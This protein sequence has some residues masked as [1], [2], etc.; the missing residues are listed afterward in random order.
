MKRNLKVLIADDSKDFGQNCA[1]TLTNYGMEVKLCEKD[2]LAI[3]E[4]IKNEDVDVVIADVFMP[5]LDV[6][7]VLSY[8]NNSDK[9]EKPLLMAMS[10]CDNEMLEKKTLEAG[11][12]YFFIKPFDVRTMAQRII[13]L[14]DLDID[15][16]PVS[17]G[18]TLSKSNT[19]S[20]AKLEIIVTEIIHD[21][22]IPAHI[23]GYHY[24]RD[25]IIVS[26]R[27]G[28]E[29]N[30]VTKILYPTIA[31]HFNT[32]SSRVE[33]AIRHAIEV[34]WDRGD[35]DVL[36]SYFGYTVQNQRGKPTNAEFIA[37]ISDK[38]RIQLRIG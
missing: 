5:H 32:T 1:K 25:A 9:E 26:V 19:I 27:Q 16:K 4:E 21:I 18:N 38:I 24:L 30:S 17:I 8:I 28:N 2:G 34:A 22:G 6:L 20:D 36:N 31:K 23:K 35:V 3:V 13:Q 37:M 10:N 29:I 33:R 7:G 12:S 15:T 11:A 14:A